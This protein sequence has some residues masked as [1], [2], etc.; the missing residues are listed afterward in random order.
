MRLDDMRREIA[1]ACRALVRKPLHSALAIT[2]LA[3][4]IGASTAVFTLLNSVVF[5]PLP[6]REPGRLV[7]IATLDAQGRVGYV[8]STALDLMERE[9]IFEGVCAFLTPQSTLDIDGRVGPAAALA[10]SGNCFTVLG[11]GPAIG[12]LL[13]PA[14]DLPGAPNVAV[15]SHEMWQRDFG[16]NVDAIGRTVRVEREPFTIV[17]VTERD[18]RGLQIGFPP[19]LML[20]LRPQAFLPTSLRQTTF[21]WNTFARLPRGTSI[22]QATV[23]L[24]TLW[25]AILEQSIPAEYEG[26]RRAAWVSSRLRIT[27][28]TTGLDSVVRTRF[29]SPL[30]ALL[31]IA[32]VVLAVACMNVANLLL[33]RGIE[34]Q[35]EHAIRAAIGASR[36]RLVREA[37]AESALLLLPAIAIGAW[38]A[39]VSVDLLISIYAATSQNFG[40]DVAPDL[41]TI[42]FVCG[43]A[44]VAWLAF[45][46]GPVIKVSAV[47]PTSILLT[48][49]FGNTARRSQLRRGLL[50]AE[51]ALTLVLVACAT[52]FAATVKELRTIPVGFGMEDVINARLAPLPGGYEKSFDPSS[53]YHGL[54]QTVKAMPGVHSVAVSNTTPFGF[55]RREPVAPAER[56]D[57]DIDVQVVRVSDNFF[58]TLRL[59]LVAGS[60]FSRTQQRTGARTAVVSRSLAERL[61]GPEEAI[62]Q[63]IRVGTLPPEQ[64]VQIIGIAPEATLG[65]PRARRR[66]IVYLNFWENPT[67]QQYAVLLIRFNAVL[68]DLAGTIRDELGRGGREYPLAIQPIADNLDNALIQERLLSIT[69]GVF[70]AIG[71]LLAAVGIFGLLTLTVANRAKEFGI[72]LAVGATRGAVFR[73]VLLDTTLSLTMGIVAGLPLVG[74][75]GRLLTTL[76]YGLGPFNILALFVTIAIVF[77]VGLVAAFLPANR[78]MRI[79]PLATLRLE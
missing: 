29:E 75:A 52:W 42:G 60:D 69:S 21:A 34:R 7:Q 40:L 17:G 14:D 66:P 70:A 61:F 20:P 24:L 57:A 36:G 33:A 79:N 5:R 44:S 64:R 78:A 41:R 71:L 53:Y 68:T 26:A 13:G 12:R 9:K 65:D 2:T 11:V 22:E 18:F 45:A 38:L 39:R 67:F 10:L 27:P 25:P 32:I 76:L 50:I 35:R 56:P 3:V 31:G 51:I 1:R 73:L 37:A 54:V 74:V 6:V 47:Q 43:I 48:T 59:P 77:V 15:L 58:A 23:R 4:G 62:G 16:G 30:T 8:A 19:R 46:L 63:D 49:S 55:V 28:A 72:R